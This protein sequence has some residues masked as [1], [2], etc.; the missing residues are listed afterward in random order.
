MPT[1]LE[2]KNLFFSYENN[3]AVL[4]NINLALKE[5]DFL[6]II[7]PNGG[8]KTTLVKILLG[9]LQPKKGNIVYPNPKIFN[10]KSLIGYVPQDTS[11]NSDF[12]IQA[13][14][15]VRMGFLK[16]RILGQALSKKK[17]RKQEIQN[18]LKILDR[19][20]IA[21]LAYRRI[22]EI[23]GGQRQR[24]LI[25][26]ALCGDPKLLILDEPTSSIDVKAQAE[27]YKI[28][29]SFNDFYTIIVISHNLSMLLEH[30]SKMLYV[31]KE[32][33]MS[34]VPKSY[35]NGHVCEIDLLNKF[36]L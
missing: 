24:V 29:K 11:L 2:C 12:P 21:H 15:V 35:V 6:A 26:R 22:S 16:K 36:A 33:V 13:L 3:E 25:A 1:L 8:G 17:S 9:L 4:K 20:G 19:L 10:P 34:D 27:I 5:K 31:N 23:S 28:L 30:A 14:D 32:I 7:G 18:A